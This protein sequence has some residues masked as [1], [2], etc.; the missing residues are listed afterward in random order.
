MSQIDRRNFLARSCLLSALGWSASGWLPA[1]AERIASRTERR[2]HCILLW[3]TGGPSQTDTFDMKP[4]HANGGPF[5]EIQTAAPG[6]RFSEHLPGLAR[7]G[8]KLA[9]VRSLSTKEGDHGR[10]TYLMRTGQ[11]PQGPIQYPAIGAIARQG[12][13]ASDRFVSELCEHRPL[14]DDQSGRLRPRVSRPAVWAAD[15]RLRQSL[16]AA[17]PERRHGLCRT[18]GRRPHGTRPFD[19]GSRPGSAGIV[20]RPADRLPG[21]QGQAAG[22]RRARH[23]LPPGTR[24]D[25][26]RGGPRVR[27]VG[28]ARCRPLAPMGAGRSA[29]AASWHAAWSSRGSPSWRCRSA[30]SAEAQAGTRT[31]ATSPAS[32]SSRGSSIKAGPPLLTELD[33]RGLL[34]TT[35]VLW[36]GEFGRTPKINGNAGRDHF[37]GAWSC[38]FAG[39]GIRGGQAY[40]KTTA[41]GMSVAERQGRCGRRAGHTGSIAR[42]RPARRKTSRRWGDR[43]RSRR[44]RPSTTSWHS[45]VLTVRPIVRLLVG[46]L[47]LL[48]RRALPATRPA[49]PLPG[50]DVGPRD[51]R[52]V[53]P[54]ASGL[55]PPARR[56]RRPEPGPLSRAGR[57]AMVPSA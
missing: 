53:C 28:R 9:V 2:R 52:P 40:G 31:P 55:C 8:K 24:N 57:H 7:H 25:E 35:T 3:M 27:S 48:G 39:G 13:G 12:I 37:P 5:H 43:S 4:G 1:F 46:W 32:S 51:R 49:Q 14:P 33:Q 50:S 21:S 36:L 38:V 44:E 26:Q 54:G 34:E 30:R 41:D 19:A 42:R 56:G 23:G 29:R 16:S 17:R 22:A 15:R 45:E 11:R 6:L 20:E 47:L 18:A 10:G